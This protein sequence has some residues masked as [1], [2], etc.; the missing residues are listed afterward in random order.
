MN[1]K[2]HAMADQRMFTNCRPYIPGE[3]EA[4]KPDILVTQGNNAKWAFES[5]PNIKNRRDGGILTL[6]GRKVRWIHSYFPNFRDIRF[7]TQKKDCW[8][9]WANMVGRFWDKQH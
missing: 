2:N 7:N 6:G 9:R 8:P 5:I 4:L 3:I 1:K